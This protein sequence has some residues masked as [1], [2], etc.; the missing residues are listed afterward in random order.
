MRAFTVMERLTTPA[1]DTRTFSSKK[2]DERKERTGRKLRICE[3]YITRVGEMS[4]YFK[5]K[6]SLVKLWKKKF[7]QGI[8]RKGKK[9]K[10]IVIKRGLFLRRVRNMDNVYIYIQTSLAM[11]RTYDPSQFQQRSKRIIKRSSQ[12]LFSSHPRSRIS[13]LSQRS[14]PI[15][16]DTYPK[17]TN[18]LPSFRDDVLSSCH[19]ACPSAYSHAIVPKHE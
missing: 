15:H 10:F 5:R 1:R 2:I 4:L 9:H 6:S 11:R 7:M 3:G 8:P 16:R 18:K 13:S 19:R 12:S 17:N 14:R